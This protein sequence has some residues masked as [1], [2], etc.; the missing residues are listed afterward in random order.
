ME[1]LP[2]ARVPNFQGVVI[3][4]CK[5]GAREK[6]RGATVGGRSEAD[7]DDS[8]G[9]AHA[10]DR[11]SKGPAV[12]TT[13]KEWRDA[14]FQRDKELVL[15]QIWLGVA[16][17]RQHREQHWRGLTR[18]STVAT[19]HTH[20]TSSD[21]GR[22]RRRR[23]GAWTKRFAS[24]IPSCIP[25]PLAQRRNPKLT[26]FLVFRSV[27]RQALLEPTLW[28]VGLIIIPRVKPFRLD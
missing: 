8:S 28:F 21:E 12:G 15:C 19:V 13:H 20:R 26:F 24:T 27:R 1:V 22:Q 2:I 11:P 14:K 18:Y 10:S 25:K 3:S 5:Q 16:L 9:S 17:V 7:D 4:Y 23:E 6:T